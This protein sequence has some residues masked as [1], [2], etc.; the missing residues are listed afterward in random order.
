MRRFLLILF[1]AASLAVPAAAS[2]APRFALWDL[3][4]DLAAASR[5]A[6][7]D[8]QAKPR[9]AVARHGTAIECAAWCRFGKGW[10]AFHAA[11]RV[12]AGDVATA[13]VGYS[14]KLGWHVRLT[15]KPSAR[16]KWDRFAAVLRAGYRQRGVPDVLVVAAGE[17][18]V[19][20]PFADQVH[21]TS[22]VLTLTGFSKASAQA[23]A[24]AVG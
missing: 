4:T 2:A 23:L 18:V 16:R 11:P 22:G 13:A 5:N 1:A 19:A 14:K 15:L 8:V 12:G 9:A 20:A 7:G 21:A 10:L 3:Q 17:R 6:F 24:A